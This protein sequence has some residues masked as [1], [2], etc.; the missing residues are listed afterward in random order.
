[1]WLLC[2]SYR[3]D[4]VVGRKRKRGRLR[5]R[6]GSFG[7]GGGYRPCPLWEISHLLALVYPYRARIGDPMGGAALTMRIATELW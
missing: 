1:M 6:S 5:E 2:E 3:E 7:D 4:S